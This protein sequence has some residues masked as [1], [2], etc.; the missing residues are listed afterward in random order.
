MK[1]SVIGTGMIGSAIVEALLNEGNKVF[2]YN[3]TANKVKPLVNLG[4]IAV[5]TPEI[6]IEESDATILAVYG[7]EILR[8]VLLNDNIKPL[9]KGKKTVDCSYIKS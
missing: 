7:G 9:L 8:E 3:R 5:S 2:V 1:I 4:A 6:A